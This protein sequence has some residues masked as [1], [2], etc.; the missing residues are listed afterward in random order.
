MHALVR[1]YDRQVVAQAAPERG[2]QRV[3]LVAVHLPHSADVS[4]EV[5][6]FHEGG[7][8]RLA[9]ARW[10]AV[11]EVARGN[12]GRHER[13]RQHG[14]AEP[15]SRKKRL[16]ERSDVHDTLSVIE[17][18]ERSQWPATV[19]EFTGVVVFD[20]PGA[21][22]SR[23]S[24]KFEAPRHRQDNA[25]WKL[26]RGRYENGTRIWSATNTFGDIDAML[27]D[28]Y[29]ANL[30]ACG[31][32]RKTG[33][34][35]TRI[36]DPDFLVGTL[37]DTGNDIDRL[38][39]A[40]SDHNLFGLAPHATCGLKII[41]NR[42]TQFQHAVWVAIAKVMPPKGP[43]RAC[44]ELAPQFGGACVHQRAPQIEG[45]LV[46]LRRH[47]DESVK[48]S[49]GDRRFGEGCWPLLAAI[50]RF[51]R[52]G[53]IGRDVGPC[54]FLADGIAF[55]KKLFESRDDCRPRHTEL[56]CEFARQGQLGRGTKRA[57]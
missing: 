47:V 19:A 34:G 57:C 7:D 18:L 3:P 53:K 44:A 13:T 4:C 43:Q 32:E 8:D 24:E 29:G 20:D 54:A 35:V 49:E 1:R 28:R 52:F 15:K 48:V 9:K 5:S 41:T 22:L 50:D 12:E 51:E 33:Q 56:R 17:A 42:L 16:V 11:H 25:F 45:A 39:G 40:R 6:L 14:V 36:F 55:S 10:M 31:D 37:H 2:D 27:V 46:A 38:L 23:T 26:V 21:R 30:R